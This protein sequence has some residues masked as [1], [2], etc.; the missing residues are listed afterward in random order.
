MSQQLHGITAVSIHAPIRVR[1][2]SVA[3]LVLGHRFQSTHPYGCDH[4]CIC[5]LLWPPVS[6]HAPIR[7]RQDFYRRVFEV[8]KVSIHAPIRVRLHILGGEVFYFVVSIHAPIR[9]RHSG[10]VLNALD[11]GFNPRTHTGATPHWDT[12]LWDGE[13]QSTHP[14]GCDRRFS[15]HTFHV[16]VS[17]HAPIRVRPKLLRRKRGL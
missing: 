13:F 4:L 9:V 3:G 11:K 5:K 17:I 10:V 15:L 7:V 2:R 12:D 6:I 1:L 14:Y 16:V 8:I